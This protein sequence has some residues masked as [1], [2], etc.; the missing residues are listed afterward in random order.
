MTEPSHCKLITPRN[1]KGYFKA[2][3]LRALA[4]SVMEIK[5]TGY[6]GKQTPQLMKTKQLQQQ[7]T[8]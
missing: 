4:E 2:F 1:P 3:V 5:L 8:E 7:V 6:L